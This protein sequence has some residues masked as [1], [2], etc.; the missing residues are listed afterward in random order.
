MT[1]S[2]GEVTLDIGYGGTFYAIIPDTELNLDMKKSSLS[3]LTTAAKEILRICRQDIKIQHPLENDLAF[4][5][6]VIITDGKD[7]YLQ[8]KD[9]ATR[10]LCYFGDGQ[11]LKVIFTYYV[12]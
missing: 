9:E 12:T 10:N 2:Y 8:F 5:Y 11:V 7:N 6:G 1:K 4:M 3:E